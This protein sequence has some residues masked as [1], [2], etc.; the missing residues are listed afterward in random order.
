MRR[1][2]SE[3]SI[4]VDVGSAQRRDGVKAPVAPRLPVIRV[5]FAERERGDFPREITGLLDRHT[6]VA[7][8]WRRGDREWVQLSFPS[9]EAR[10]ADEH[11]G[12][13]FE[14]HPS[15]ERAHDEVDRVRTARHHGFDLV[16]IVRPE[17]PEQEHA[18]AP[19]DRADE[20]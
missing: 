17:A 7:V 10:D 1:E 14:H 13:G 5:V 18:I 9:L 2:F 19:R 4:D 6:E 12:A 3:R 8:K 11:E 16:A 20:Q 15:F